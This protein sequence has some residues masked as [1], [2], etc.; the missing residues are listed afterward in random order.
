MA[1]Q[2]L[3]VDPSAS[4]RRILEAMVLANVN[5]AVV[6]HARNAEEAT[7]KVQDQGC[8]VLIATWERGDHQGLDFFAAVKKRPKRTNIP[9]IVLVSGAEQGQDNRLQEAGVEEIVSM[10]CTA[11]VLC[12]AI[13]RA[14][15][16]V[17][18]RQSKRYS[19][20]ETAVFLEQGTSRLPAA[21]VNI[22]NGGLLCELDFPGHFNC[23]APVLLSILFRVD[24]G[25]L[26]AS[27]LL[28]SFTGMKVIARNPDFSP[29]RIRLAFFFIKV[30]DEASEIL[31]KVF[32]HAEQQEMELR[33]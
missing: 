12:D 28:S 33:V 26:N 19:L 5:D 17:R 14:C 13:N 24:G 25:E 15:N 30:P 7:A 18:L 22:S 9:L 10:P 21:L 27:G 11:D 23:G 16:P 29:R 3:I 31:A 32:V 20:P 4:M 1:R 8:H 6:A 2:I